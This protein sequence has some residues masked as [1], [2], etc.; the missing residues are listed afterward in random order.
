VQ[1]IDASKMF[2]KAAKSLGDKR[3]VIPDAAIAEITRV[4]GDFEDGPASRVV[5]NE[6]LGYR[7]VTV[8][9]P[10]RLRFEASP[11]SLAALA[12][13]KALARLEPAVQTTFVDEIGRR[14]GRAGLPAALDGAA[15]A[16]GV[17]VTAALRSAVMDALGRRDPAAPPVTG[18]EGR[19]VA[20]PELRDV[21]NVPLTE[22][23]E[24]YL[25]REVHPQ[26]PD[27]WLD[28]ART[29]VGYEIP[30]SR[31]FFQYAF[32]RPLPQIDR[33]LRASVA[34]LQALVAEVLP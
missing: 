21:E 33:D 13:A 12:G 31:W 28:D 19:P 1:L 16:A 25:R 6:E 30:F 17:R 9:R 32:P 4:F 2:E 29:R 15:R 23:P 22:E 34:R 7:Q 10:L 8:E 26:A 5:D 27:A 14:I 24:E 20:D 11:E 3:N 18:A